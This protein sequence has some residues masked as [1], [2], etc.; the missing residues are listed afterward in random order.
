MI[1]IGTMPALSLFICVL[2]YFIIIDFILSFYK[3]KDCI[4]AEIGL[5]AQ[6]FLFFLTLALRLP[7]SLEQLE[8]QSSRCLFFLLWLNNI[9][10]SMI[11]FN[12]NF[13]VFE[14]T[15]VKAKILCFLSLLCLQTEKIFLSKLSVN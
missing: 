5:N 1:F 14:D 12:S 10:I 2:R 13:T 4:Y 6:L 8:K 15:F 7:D 11:L 9:H 3:I